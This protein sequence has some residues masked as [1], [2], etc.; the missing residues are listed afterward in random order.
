M[1]VYPTRAT[2][3]GY[4]SGNCNCFRNFPRPRPD[5]S[6]S[7]VRAGSSL[8]PFS[9]R[10]GNA[11]ISN[12]ANHR[13]K[14]RRVLQSPAKRARTCKAPFRGGCRRKEP[15][16]IRLGPQSPSRAAPCTFQRAKHPHH[17][18]QQRPQSRHFHG[19]VPATPPNTA[20][21]FLAR[22][23][24]KATL[25]FRPKASSPRKA[26]AGQSP[27]TPR[28]CYNAGVSQIRGDALHSAHRRPQSRLQIKGRA[29]RNQ[30]YAPDSPKLGKGTTP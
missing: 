3:L 10:S 28:S 24:D 14:L 5:Q 29:T 7:C 6:P 16:R 2:P 30:R 26:L 11:A 8:R 17:Q 4:C 19:S 18:K 22:K 25:R 1:A 21:K 20:S 12:V 23:S 13:K 9:H 15:A 27:R